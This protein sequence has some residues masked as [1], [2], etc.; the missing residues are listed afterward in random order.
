MKTVTHFPLLFFDLGKSKRLVR[1]DLRDIDEIALPFDLT[2]VSHLSN[3]TLGIV[4]DAWHLAWVKPWRRIIDGG[5]SLSV[6]R[7]VGTFAIIVL[8]EQIKLMLLALM[9][10]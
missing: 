7:L 3:H 10:G 9:S 5:W 1:Q 2:V 8:L 4:L 6:E